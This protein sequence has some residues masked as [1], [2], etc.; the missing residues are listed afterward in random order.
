M[1]SHNVDYLGGAVT[2]RSVR[3]TQHV[4]ETKKPLGRSLGPDRI[5]QLDWYR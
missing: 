1:A 2:V 3:M 5:H 4:T